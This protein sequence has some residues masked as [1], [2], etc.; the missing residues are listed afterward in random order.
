MRL[1][2]KPAGVVL[3]VLLFVLAGL[4]K[5]KLEN[6]LRNAI[7]GKTFI[8]RSTCPASTLSFDPA[9]NLAEN[10]QGKKW[11]LYSTFHAEKLWLSKSKLTVSGKRQIDTAVG[12]D[13]ET[14]LEIADPYELVLNFELPAPLTDV[15]SATSVLVGA[16]ESREQ[17]AK[18]LAPY[19]AIFPAEPL[20]KNSEKI[21]K[22][23]KKPPVAPCGEEKTRPVGMLGPDRFIYGNLTDCSDVRFEQPRA[24]K[25]R[26]PQYTNAAR[27]AGVS[28]D[29]G[30]QIVVNERGLLEVIRV[31]SHLG[32]GLDESA[33]KEVA[34]WKFTPA[35]IEGKPVAV[36]LRVEMSFHLVP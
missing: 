4:A 21:E 25:M 29:D 18:E 12:P 16:F 32:Y 17:R 28:G 7:L 23:E 13:A 33:V 36:T 10:C 11:A 2:S 19:A 1:W 30:M 24:L 20:E 27:E 14:P 9:G 34:S 26:D 31:A 15:Q 3:F 8:L 22:G 5:P 35:R 6:E